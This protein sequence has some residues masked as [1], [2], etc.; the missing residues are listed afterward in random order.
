M[1]SDSAARRWPPAVLGGAAGAG[2]SEATEDR[3]ASGT[4]ASSE[5]RSPFHRLLALPRMARRLA[6]DLKQELIFGAL[7][8]HDWLALRRVRPGETPADTLITRTDGIG[9]FVLW[10]SSTK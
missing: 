7:V 6:S 2:M 1:P 8:A 4:A 5:M 3:A 9:D 10:L